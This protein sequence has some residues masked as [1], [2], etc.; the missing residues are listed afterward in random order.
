MRLLLLITVCL[1]FVATA[2]A[3]NARGIRSIDFHNFTYETGQKKFVLR[4]GVY[5]EG[6]S[7]SWYSHTLSRVKY[8]DF[9]G[10]GNDEAFV[11][12][13]FKT[14]GTLNNAQD[15]FVFAYLSGAPQMI[16]HEWRE[17]P[18]GVSVNRRRIVI[19]APFWKD[20]GLCC[21]SG[22]EKSVYLWRKARFVL[23]SHKRR[24]LDP[25]T[26]WWLTVR[27]A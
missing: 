7:G 16:F 4:E 9:D 10:D 24:Y 22:I 14:S 12:V 27:R 13:D 8:L 15:Y 1:F 6:D 23:V 19:D 21:P 3:Q 17:K 26:N 2:V 5:Y 25:N 20:G 11:V 18:R